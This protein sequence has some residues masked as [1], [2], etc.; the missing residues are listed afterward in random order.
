[1]T[2][3]P[4]RRAL[5]RPLHILLVAFGSAVFASVITLMT[6]RDLFF[7]ADGHPTFPITL[8]VVGVTFIGVL[9]ILALLIL[10][11]DPA[12][13]D[14]RVDRAVLL[15]PEVEPAAEAKPTDPQAL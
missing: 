13:F 5:L 6:T 1:M 10:A 9:L 14:R 7:I 11:V 3:K 12:E 4:T 15:P 2:D 8:V